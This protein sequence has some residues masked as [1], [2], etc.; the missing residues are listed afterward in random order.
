MADGVNIVILV[1]NVGK[2]PDYRNNTTPVVNFS[3]ATQK[4]YKKDDQWVN[5]TTWHNI[6]AFGRTAE[7]VNAKICKG[8][9]IFVEGELDVDEWTDKNGSKRQTTKV[10]ANKINIVFQKDKK[11]NEAQYKS[12]S[13]NDDSFEDEVPF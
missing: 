2:D 13:N 4:S 12:Q 6:V 3:L 11:E 10:K 7:Y 8:N 9:T 5:K 1:G